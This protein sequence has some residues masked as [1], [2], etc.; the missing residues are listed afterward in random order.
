MALH[1]RYDQHLMEE[2]FRKSRS[3][4]MIVG[5]K[6][7]KERTPNFLTYSEKEQIRT[8]HEKD[9][10]MWTI[11]KLSESFPADPFTINLILKANWTPRNTKRIQRHDESVIRNWENFK[12]G[13]VKV[14]P[15]LENHLKKFAFRDLNLLAKPVPFRKLGV[16]IPKPVSNEFTKIITSC[17]KYAEKSE[18]VPEEPKRVRKIESQEL[19]LPEAINDENVD[20]YLMTGRS[21]IN[22]P[23]KRNI[24]FEELRK[25][26]SEINSKMQEN[27]AAQK[28]SMLEEVKNL[29]VKKIS[30]TK[31][32]DVIALS[33]QEQKINDSLEIME[34]ISIPKNLWKQGGTYKL[35]DCFYDDDGEFLYRVPGLVGPK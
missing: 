33:S 30:N 3:G 6:Y 8:L 34:R 12:E 20:S 29:K 27:E 17:T 35:D 9:P 16:E 10:E 7:F 32:N 22:V 5:K 31:S 4:I 18:E 21:P 19:R 25:Y 1:E 24:T 28:G 11:E 2:K 13:K 15:L 26:S 23:T 14:E